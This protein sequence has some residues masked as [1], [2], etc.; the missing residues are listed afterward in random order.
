[1]HEDH[2]RHAPQPAQIA[3]C[4]IGKQ[5]NQRRPDE[6]PASSGDRSAA[7]RG[8]AATA[9]APAG[10]QRVSETKCW[11]CSHRRI[12]ESQS[13]LLPGVQATR[14]HFSAFFRVSRSVF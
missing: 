10:A 5:Q 11:I 1:L 13:C 12:V 6:C 7:R 14:Q 8:N 3:S 9:L 2:S 4:P